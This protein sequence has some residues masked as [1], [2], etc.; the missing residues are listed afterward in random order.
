VKMVAVKMGR[1][2]V[3]ALLA[4]YAS[5]VSTGASELVSSYEARCDGGFEED[6]GGGTRG[7]SILK[8]DQ[9]SVVVGWC[10]FPSVEQYDE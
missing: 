3:S 5:E 6:R 1:F 2:C 4:L 8:S 7:W 9:G 10:E